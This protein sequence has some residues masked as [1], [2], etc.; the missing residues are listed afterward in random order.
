MATVT[1]PVTGAN[2]T[3]GTAVAVRMCLCCCRTNPKASSKHN[4]LGEE[5]A[6]KPV[7]ANNAA[8]A[9]S[10]AAGANSTT[11]SETTGSGR[12]SVLRLQKTVPLLVICFYSGLLAAIGCREPGN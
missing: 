11:G 10:P 12:V 1:S 2:S 7:E 4:S 5:T 6:I 8:T 9:T 3:T